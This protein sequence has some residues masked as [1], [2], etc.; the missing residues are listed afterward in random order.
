MRTRADEWWPQT[1]WHSFTTL[2]TQGL[3]KD[4]PEDQLELIVLYGSV[5]CVKRSAAFVF[6]ELVLPDPGRVPSVDVL[7][8]LSFF[9]LGEVLFF[10]VFVMNIFIG[11]ISEQYA[12]EQLIWVDQYAG[13]HK[14]AKLC[15]GA[16]PGACAP[17]HC[18]DVFGVF[19]SLPHKSTTPRHGRI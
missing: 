4:P 2:I 16:P 10:S 11:V 17:A 5:L 6:G 7:R 3:P 15:P 9:L 12:S 14:G 8:A 13:A 19:V 18:A 1:L